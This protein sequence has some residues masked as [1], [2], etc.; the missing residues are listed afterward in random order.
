MSA[1]FQSDNNINK[2]NSYSDTD[3][4]PY[5][6][7]QKN[8]GRYEDINK[9]EKND[10]SE[11]VNNNEVSINKKEKRVNPFREKK[12]IFRDLYE[13]GGDDIGVNEKFLERSIRNDETDDKG[14]KDEKEEAVGTERAWSKIGARNKGND[15]M[16]KVKN[17]SE[18]NDA[19]AE[20][21]IVK[22]REKDTEEKEKEGKEKAA[23]PRTGSSAEDLTRHNPFRKNGK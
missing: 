10:T 12:E 6:E 13:D 4:D 16:E 2:S 18:N 21:E 17:N 14:G 20:R 23:L 7:K 19:E 9:N 5:A 15:S 1:F 22:D 8:D 3:N 11:M